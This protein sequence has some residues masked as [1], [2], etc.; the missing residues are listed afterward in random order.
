MTDTTDR[1]RAGLW[2]KFVL[3]VGLIGLAILP[4][5]SLGSRWGL[6]PFWTGI[7]VLQGACLLAVIALVLGIAALVRAK[8]RQRP[9]DR[10]PAAVGTLASAF[11]LT[12]M[13]LQ[14]LAATSVPAIHNISTDRD[15]PPAFDAIAALRGPGSNPLDYDA[16]DAAA[17]AAGYPDLAGLETSLEPAAALAR[18]AAVGEAMG[19][20]VVA[21]GPWGADV[22]EGAVE[23]TATTFWFGFKDDVAIRVRAEAAGSKVDVRSVSRVG[24]SDLGANAA[25]IRAFLARFEDA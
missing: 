19:W 16:G 5:G 8:L 13:G 15:D 9:R 21:A 17:Q 24:L 20:E 6:W 18:A 10:L 22:R 7:Q 12:W 4:A 11:V 25:R 1:G 23:A 2:A 3:C 14:Y